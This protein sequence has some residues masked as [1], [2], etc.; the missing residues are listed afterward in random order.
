[1]NPA[2]LTATLILYMLCSSTGMALAIPAPATLAAEAVTANQAR[3]R[4]S[5]LSDTSESV[6]VFTYFKIGTTPPPINSNWIADGEILA[7][8]DSVTYPIATDVSFTTMATNLRCGTRYYY[9]AGLRTGTAEDFGL[10]K[11]GDILDFTTQSCSPLPPN[12][13]PTLS[14]WALIMMT[15]VMVATAE[16]FGWIKKLR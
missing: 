9:Q 1:M 11:E 15:L 14:E 6:T 10:L 8:P 5:A 7:S 16:L 4:A 12:P 2:S 3:L 13:V